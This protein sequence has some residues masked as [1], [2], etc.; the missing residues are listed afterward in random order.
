MPGLDLP[1]ATLELMIGPVIAVPAPK[2]ITEALESVTVTH[3]ESGPCGFQLTFNADRTN[4][5]TQDYPL[6]LSHALMVG[7]RVVIVIVLSNG[8]PD[9]ISDGFITHMQMAHSKAF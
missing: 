7:M 5:F 8:V 4:A 6:L 1:G 3:P 2:F 9:V